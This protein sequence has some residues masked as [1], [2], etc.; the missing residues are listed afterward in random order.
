MLTR[1]S[2]T[3]NIDHLYRPTDWCTSVWRCWQVAW[4]SRLKEAQVKYKNAVKQ[5]HNN[6]ISS[7]DSNTRRSRRSSSNV[8]QSDHVVPTTTTTK[9]TSFP[10]SPR[11]SR[12]SLTQ[13]HG[14]THG[15]TLLT[16]HR[17]VVPSASLNSAFWSSTSS[18][19]RSTTSSLQSISTFRGNAATYGKAVISRTSSAGPAMRGIQ[20]EDTEF[21]QLLQQQ[22]TDDDVDGE[23]AVSVGRRIG[24]LSQAVRLQAG[25]KASFSQSCPCLSLAAVTGPDYEFAGEDVQSP[26]TDDL[27][28]SKHRRLGSL[29]DKVQPRVRQ[30]WDQLISW[31]LTVDYMWPCIHWNGAFTQTE[32]LMY[33][34]TDITYRTTYILLGRWSQ[35]PQAR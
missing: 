3:A 22:T 27:D 34:R 8:T 11:D 9:T 24:Y 21:W 6:S 31:S 32:S 20:E 4:L 28:N 16:G 19:R 12:V 23:S 29:V 7:D 17:R 26:G 30:K 2:C 10:R 15:T 25:I 35:S 18:D 13:Q 5:T 14:T 1:A 33:N